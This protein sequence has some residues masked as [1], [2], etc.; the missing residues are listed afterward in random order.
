MTSPLFTGSE[1]AASG[2][3]GSTQPGVDP[4]LDPRRHGHRPPPVPLA[5]HVRQ[6]PPSLALLEIFDV[7]ADELGAAQAAAEQ[8]GQDGSVALAGQ[9]LGVGRVEQI[10]RLVLQQPVADP[11]ALPL[12]F[13]NPFD[14]RRRRGVEQLVV[15]H[16]P[17]QLGVTTPN[18]KNRTLVRPG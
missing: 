5:D 13:R 17:G 3:P 18:V 10:V 12:H 8:H 15:G 4:G 14:R 16:L 2:N 1:D 6:H 11:R 7:D 9:G